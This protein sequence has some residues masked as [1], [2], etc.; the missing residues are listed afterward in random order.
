MSKRQT[1]AAEIRQLRREVRAL[2]RERDMLVKGFEILMPGAKL[3]KHGSVTLAV[4][5]RRRSRR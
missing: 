2:T 4:G 1:G 3:S 5:R